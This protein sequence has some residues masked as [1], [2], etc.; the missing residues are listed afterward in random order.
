MSRDKN[1]GL[2][3]VKRDLLADWILSLASVSRQGYIVPI[4]VVVESELI[5]AGLAGQM[6]V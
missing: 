6:A 4:R 1:S 3:T 5:A 2:D